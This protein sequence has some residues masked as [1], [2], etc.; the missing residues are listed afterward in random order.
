[1]KCMSCVLVQS[2]PAG[3]CVQ[4]SAASGRGVKALFMCLFSSVVSQL[5]QAAP[6]L[7][8]SAAQEALSACQAEGLWTNGLNS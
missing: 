4:V 7:I 5:P 3:G 2:L 6:E 8:A 1:M